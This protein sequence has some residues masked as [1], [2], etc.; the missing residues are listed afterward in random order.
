MG[1]GTSSS[2]DGVWC[3]EVWHI[4]AAKV[5]S[6]QRSTQ[7]LEKARTRDTDSLQTWIWGIRR[8][9]GT[10]TCQTI[11]PRLNY[12]VLAK[13]WARQGKVGRW[14]D[15][16]VH[17]NTPL[18]PTVLKI[19]KRIN[20]QCSP[21]MCCNHDDSIEETMVGETSREL[22]GQTVMLLHWQLVPFGCL[23][24]NGGEILQSN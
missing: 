22:T 9:K 24:I 19:I 20:S 3:P 5:T 4:K 12:R 21:E 10:N 13:I 18:I 14:T 17:D 1:R 2:S 8:V 23:F 6:T 7:Y 11:S 15:G 16:N